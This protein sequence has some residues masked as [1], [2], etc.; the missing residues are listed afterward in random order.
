MKTFRQRRK[1]TSRRFARERSTHQDVSPEKEVLIK[2]FR[3]R[4]KYTS[5]R[6]AR[7]RSTHQDVSPEKEV[8]IKTFDVP[9]MM[10]SH[11]CEPN[12]TWG[13]FSPQIC[14]DLK[15]QPLPTE[16]TPDHVIQQNDISSVM[17][18]L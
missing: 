6:F 8:H 17:L 1:Y 12:Q 3:Q 13:E 5:R 15:T 9:S 4:K 7:E 18:S 14:F 2:T 11:T 16:L 10:V